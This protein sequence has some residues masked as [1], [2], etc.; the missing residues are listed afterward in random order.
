MKR[1]VMVG[2]EGTDDQRQ[3]RDW[4]ANPVVIGVIAVAL[5]AFGFLAFVFVANRLSD[6]DETATAAPEATT[7]SDENES[8]ADG[9]DEAAETAADDGEDTAS[10]AGED[11]SDD[12]ADAEGTDEPSEETEDAPKPEG[13]FVEATLNLDAGP[14]PGLFVLSGRVPDQETADAMLQAAEISY[15]PFVES[16][17]EVD[18]DLDP[19]PWLAAGPN[20]IGL[21]PSITDGTI[22]LVDGQVELDAR[23]PNPQYLALLEG[24]LG[25]LSGD[26]AVEVVDTEITDLRP[27]LF[28]A[29]VDNGS[30]SLSGFVPSE[31]IREILV[32]GAAAAY[33]PENVQ[34]ELT[35][36]PETY[37]SFWMYTMPGIFQLFSPFPKYSLEV[38]EG[39][40]SGTLQGGVVFDVDST[41]IT[42]EAA[43]VL[44]VGVAILARDPSIFMTVEGHTDSSG[45]DAYNEA[46]SLG[47]A[48]SVTAYLQAAGIEAERLQSIGAG[49][50][51]PI[52]SN[53]TEEGKALNR[54]VEFVFGPPPG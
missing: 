53:D 2:Y 36:D 40:S 8:S 26:M 25:L 20:V 9:D 31:E 39:V 11:A 46:L 50:S 6:G 14:G 13:A 12:D 54:R 4:T 7:A 19:A 45:S 33:G 49:E 52:A 41:E 1:G 47:R 51:D 30:V 44:N 43:Q 34:S 28:E 24:A 27:P 22:R 3:G 42:P 18:E 5:F 32:G 48:Q 29:E 15:A 35:I 16:D 23:S 21:L 37:I 17:I 10:E 38:A